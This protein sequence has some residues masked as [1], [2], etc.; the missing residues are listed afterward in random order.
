METVL[1]TVNGTTPYMN[2]YGRTPNMLPDINVLGENLEP[3]T[4]RHTNRL[5]EISLQQT[6]E[7]T[8][9]EKIKR[10]LNS[11]TRV[12]AQQH[13]YKIGELVDYHRHQPNKDSSGWRGPAKVVD[14][15]EI[16]RGIVII[17]HQR[18]MPIECRLQD[19][20]RYLTY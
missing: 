5:R 17:R 9:A 15:T 6:I 1:I 11:K 10:C 3:G 14:N 20:R 13:D 12:S 4:I 8:A 16:Q 7:G 2:V 19:V 18:E